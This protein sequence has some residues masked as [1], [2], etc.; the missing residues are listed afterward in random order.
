[1]TAIKGADRAGRASLVS[2]GLDGSA[3]AAARILLL[4]IGQQG[5]FNDDPDF[6]AIFGRSRTLTL[7]IHDQLPWEAAH[8]VRG[9]RL[10][11][12][13]RIGIQVVSVADGLQALGELSA[14]V[15]DSSVVRQSA[16]RFW[17]NAA[18]D[19]IGTAARL[20]TLAKR[21]E[22]TANQ[23]RALL[24]GFDDGLAWW[25]RAVSWLLTHA[26]LDTPDGP[27]SPAQLMA[28]FWGVDSLPL[29]EI[30]PTRFGGTAAMPQL[31]VTHVAPFLFKPANG[32]AVEWLQHQSWGIQEAFA[33]WRPLRWGESP[34]TVVIGGRAATVASP[35]SQ[36]IVH[37][38]SF[39]GERDAILIDPGIMPLAAV[40][41]FLHEWNHL[42]AA[43]RRL[44]G[45]HPVAVVQSASQLQLREEDPWLAEGFAEWATDE[46]LRPAGASAAFLRLT[47][48][49]KRLGISTASPNDPHVLGFR[50]VRGVASTHRAPMLREL[51][52]QNLHDLAG[53]AH[54]A[55]LPAGD[56]GNAITLQRPATAIVIPEVTFTWDEGTTLDLSRR[57]VIPNIRSEH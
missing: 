57:L 38:A 33:V 22:A 3:R 55:G 13:P 25:R 56:K 16:W 24:A 48:A 37:P 5:G 47:Q 29:P 19:S 32:S 8:Y 6:K 52:V 18:T 43:Q 15:T 10:M 28:A 20:D 14:G 26:W 54:A 51:L 7:D 4:R 30:R 23:L 41:T 17:S 40:A 49:E 53:F 1:M 44:A 46:V 50:L 21:D 35:A 12:D 42:L 45:M 27:R 9:F 36:A 39:F 11:Q 2:L 34:L 31:S